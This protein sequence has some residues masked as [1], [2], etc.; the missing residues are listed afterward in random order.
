[1]AKN[2][3]MDAASGAELDLRKNGN[4]FDDDALAK[5]GSLQDALDALSGLGATVDSYNE[6]GTGFSVVD[7]QTLAGV[8]FVI[9]EWRFN[10]G[11]YGEFVSCLIVTKDGVKAVLNDGSTGV[12]KELSM[13]TASRLRNGV[14]NTQSGLIVENGL[15]RGDYTYTDENGKE[16]PATTWHLVA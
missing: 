8:P 16:T 10:N 4:V 9:L 11:T 7:K 13:V 15:K 6:Y 3:K 2:E 5:I 14:A 12:C 1:M